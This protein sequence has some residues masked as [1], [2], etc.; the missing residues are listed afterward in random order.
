ML[1]FEATTHLIKKFFASNNKSLEFNEF[2]K[3]T[4]EEI[5]CNGQCV[6]IWSLFLIIMRQKNKA[7]VKS[8][9]VINLEIY[10]LYKYC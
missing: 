1:L 6:I 8:R 9:F 3:R 7:Q 5:V 10:N 4:I 2:C